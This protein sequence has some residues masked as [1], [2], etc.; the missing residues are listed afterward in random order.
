MTNQLIPEGNIPPPFHL[1]Y[2]PPPLGDVMGW[3]IL[4]HLLRAA[5]SNLENPLK[6]FRV[7]RHFE[8]IASVKYLIF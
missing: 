7:G 6:V 5:A 3:F 1:H 2:F 8:R 4:D